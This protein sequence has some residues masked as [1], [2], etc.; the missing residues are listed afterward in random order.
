M[1]NRKA[2]ARHLRDGRPSL[3]T[4]MRSLLQPSIVRVSVVLAILLWSLSAQAQSAA[5]K[6]IYE[7]KLKPGQRTKV[8]EGTVGPPHGK[9]DMSNSGSEKYLLPVRAGQALMIELSSENDRA[10]FSIIKPSP[11][12]AKDEQVEKADGV[13]SWAGRLTKSGDYLVTVF[14]RDRDAD[15]RFKLRVTLH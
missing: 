4:P 9:G 13:K 14:T 3:K 1:N 15:S 2:R 8:V 12:M 6:P 11:N 10:L 5:T 7:I